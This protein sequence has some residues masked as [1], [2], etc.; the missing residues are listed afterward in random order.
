MR[1]PK[2]H[3]WG[4]NLLRRAADRIFE[5]KETFNAVMLIDNISSK[6]IAQV[7]LRHI[8]EEYRGVSLAETRLR[9]ETGILVMLVEHRGGNTAAAQAETVFEPGDRL[10]VFGDY[11]AICSAFHAREH[12]A[13]E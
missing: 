13:D 10:T 8:P 12:F 5:R 7:T 1:V 2:I 6:S 9:A 11:R 4:D 3:A